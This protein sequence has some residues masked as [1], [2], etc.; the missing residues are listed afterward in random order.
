MF[1]IE[2]GEA[3][4]M[5]RGSISVPPLCALCLCGEVF[6]S[7]HSY[8]SPPINSRRLKL[9]LAQVFNAVAEFGGALKLHIFG[10][11]AHFRFEPRNS[12]VEM[13]A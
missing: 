5:H 1:T 13:F 6:L 7:I 3:R 10:G 9:T 2:A 11:D 8:K 4:R 12:R